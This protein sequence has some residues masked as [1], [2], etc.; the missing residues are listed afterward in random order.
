MKTNLQVYYT[1]K[2]SAVFPYSTFIN[3]FK[4]FWNWNVKIHNDFHY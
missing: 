4:N 2:N 1:G 3:T